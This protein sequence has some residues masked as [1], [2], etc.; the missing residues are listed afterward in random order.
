MS[1]SSRFT[2]RSLWFAVLIASA[3]PIG[4]A[5]LTPSPRAAAA[6]EAIPATPLETAEAA[7]YEIPSE[8]PA[9]RTD[10]ADSPAGPFRGVTQNVLLIPDSTADRI[11]GFD[12]ATGNLISAN[13]VPADPTN[14]STPKA[15]IANPSGAEVWVVDQ[16]DD[17]VQRYGAGGYLG[18]FA[19]AGGVNTAILDNAT[20]M[21]FHPNGNLLVAVQSG[22]NGNSVAAFD[23]GGNHV[24]NFIAIGA[25]GLAGPFD[26]LVRAADVLVSSINTDQILRYDRTTG[27]FLDV[28]ASVNNFPQQLF[29]AANGNI[30]VA[31][32][33]GTQEGIV[34]F[35]SAGALV[36]V[37]D[38]IAAGGYRGVYELPNLNLLVT[39]GTGVFEISRANTLVSTKMGSVSAQYIEFAASQLPVGLIEF[40]ID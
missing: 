33:G 12:P 26:I 7:G 30:L 23:A 32:F 27:A 13:F 37:Y 19:P 40:G 25:G 36:A 34:E 14:L 11:M 6:A 18:V 24:G 15:A 17:A 38:P 1:D 8:L 28:F 29:E 22:A 16:L 2:Y 10:P 5:D 39:T 20:G 9:G 21:T 31:N 4:A 35:T 3:L